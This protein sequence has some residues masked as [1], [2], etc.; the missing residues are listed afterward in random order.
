LDD[1]WEILRNPTVKQAMKNIMGN[2]FSLFEQR[3]QKLF[4][5]DI[6]GDEIFCKG[7]GTGGFSYQEGVFSFNTNTRRLQVA[8]LDCD[9]L[10]IWGASK[11]E[12]LSPSMKKYVSLLQP[13]HKV[14][15]EAPNQSAI[16]LMLPESRVKRR[17]SYASPT[18]TYER[19][20]QW[21]HATLKIAKIANDEI[22]FDLS[23]EYGF[24]GGNASGVVKLKNSIAVY[25]DKDRSIQL[26]FSYEGKFIDVDLKGNRGGFGGIGV[27]ADGKYV[28]TDDRTPHFDL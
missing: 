13:D 27:Y 10:D 12:E 5:P 21:D 3:T 15:F 17:I 19:K 22:K 2:K 28:K 18:G 16:K 20:G 24:H 4:E 7:G 9:N 14:T 8:L 6:D 23:A 11:N 1:G 25:T 26:I